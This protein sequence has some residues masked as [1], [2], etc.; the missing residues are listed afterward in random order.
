MLFWFDMDAVTGGLVLLGR[1][2]RD[3][4]NISA[5]LR[6]SVISGADFEISEA[7]SRIFED[8]SVG[9]LFPV[10]IGLK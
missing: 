2:S 7:I 1:Y 3:F 10:T 6:S 5:G 8:L 9:D 4:A